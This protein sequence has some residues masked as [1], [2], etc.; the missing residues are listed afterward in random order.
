MKSMLFCLLLL[1]SAVQ[2]YPQTNE[3]QTV[4]NDPNAEVRKLPAFSGIQVSHGIALFVK[5]GNQHGVA[6][7]ASEKQYRDRI[8]T[9]VENGVLKIYYDNEGWLKNENK[10]NKKLKAYVSVNNLEKLTGSSGSSIVI[11]GSLNSNKL[12]LDLSSGS[13]FKGDVRASELN[14]EQSSGAVSK[15]S[16]KAKKVNVETSSGSSVHG[17]DLSSDFCV[18]SAHSGGHVEISVNTELTGKASSGG[19]VRYKGDGVIKTKSTSSGGSVSKN[20]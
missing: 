1:I 19:N 14:I 9:A 7:S 11:D 12:V 15:I 18:A 8:R 17:Y 3:P 5:Q 20:G 16:G 13:N 4:I 6:V 10:S 2:A